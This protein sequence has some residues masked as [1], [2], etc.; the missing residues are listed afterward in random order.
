[1][2]QQ[3][4]ITKL[5]IEK[6]K[7]EAIRDIKETS[8]NLDILIYT[9]EDKINLIPYILECV[10]E[11]KDRQEMIEMCLKNKGFLDEQVN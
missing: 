2:V 8:R 9:L 6:A 4:I 7:T 5:E 11:L 1:M 10:R 3:E